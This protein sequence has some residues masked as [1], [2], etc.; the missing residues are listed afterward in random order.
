MP[1]KWRTILLLSASYIF[2]AS[3]NVHFFLLL[4][5]SSSIDYVLSLGIH[6]TSDNFK[7][8]SI[9]FSGIFFN[10]GV[11]AFYKYFNIFLQTFFQ[12]SKF[13]LFI[14]L[15]LGLSFYTFHKLSYLID[16][17]KGK[18]TP[19]KFID[20]LLYIAYFPKLI[21]GPIERTKSFIAK[22]EEEKY[23]RKIKIKESLYL[24]LYGIFKKFVISSSLLPIF[25]DILKMDHPSVSQLVL[26]AYFISFNVYA[27]FS[28][29]TDI[30]RGISLLFG[31]ELDLNFEFPYFTKNPLEFFKKW[32]ITLM[33][34]MKDYIYMPLFVFFSS[35]TPVKH[36]EN[37]KW[38]F[39]ASS[40]FA[41]FFT[42]FIFGF[43]HGERGYMLLGM[44][45]F[46]IICC[47]I[48]FEKL[49]GKIVFK[50]GGWFTLVID[51]IRIIINFNV[52]SLGFF[53]TLFHVSRTF[54]FVKS[55]F[56]EFNFHD[57]IM[58]VSFQIFLLL[59]FFFV[60]ELMQYLYKDALFICKK[61]FEMQI[62]FYLI[63]FFF[64]IN[65][66]EVQNTGF[67]YVQ[68]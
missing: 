31:I 19:P 4:F 33:T 3:I 20:Y 43:W 57:L 60:Y 2:Y 9:F 56:F 6:K 38:R 66:G 50:R 51:V 68:F 5:F 54:S 12:G 21:S 15:P 46:V 42:F 62:L 25:L 24:I 18:I 36:F 11:W 40:L 22:L 61:N 23:F 59:L 37:A 13:S 7:K 63:L 27:D 65:A 44:Y 8:K 49:L 35:K 14:I 28:G 32:H 30:V 26:A 34:W 64:F 17:Y 48:F 55:L 10:L 53:L 39:G 16:V 52:I 45:S 58:G 29:Y 47:F 41:L 1:K 67:L